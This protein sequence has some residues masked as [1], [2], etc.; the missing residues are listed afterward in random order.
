MI[1][2]RFSE[3]RN[4]STHTV[5]LKYFFELFI[6]NILKDDEE[7]AYDGYRRDMVPSSSSS[8]SNGASPPY[9]EKDRDH[10]KDK[11]SSPPKTPLEY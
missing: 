3:I 5:S 1:S 8:G 11:E 2:L 7:G 9:R 4:F 10:R 6:L